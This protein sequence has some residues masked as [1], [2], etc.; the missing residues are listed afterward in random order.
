M[1]RYDVSRSV[2]NKS[3]ARPSR[4]V[5]IDVTANALTST[6]LTN[7]NGASGFATSGMRMDASAVVRV[8]APELT[9]EIM[10]KA[11]AAASSQYAARMNR[12]FRPYA[13]VHISRQSTG[14][15]QTRRLFW[16]TLRVRSSTCPDRNFSDSFSSSV[17]LPVMT[18][19]SLAVVV[20]PTLMSRLGFQGRTRA[21]AIPHSNTEME[22]A[23]TR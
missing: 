4:S 19:K 8:A 15:S 2:R 23:T 20:C 11:T 22:I 1:H 10:A 18:S 9:N 7:R 14:L 21:M 12:I 6:I 16:L 17:N 5:V 3:I 13:H